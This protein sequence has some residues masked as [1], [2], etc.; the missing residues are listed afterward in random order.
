[1][2]EKTCFFTGNRN[3]SN[4]DYEQIFY[5]N[6]II[7]EILIKEK[8]VTYFKV[9]IDRE[10]DIIAILSIIKIKKAYPNIRLILVMPYKTPL[11][12]WNKK[13]YNIAI[14]N[15]DEIIYIPEYY[16]KDYIFK[17][18]NK[19]IE[20]SD[21]CIAYLR[22]NTKRCGIFYTMLKA[23]NKNIKIYNLNNYLDWFLSKNIGADILGLLQ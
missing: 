16:T 5:L 6:T 13:I 15:A 8:E 21:Y 20:N 22:R 18:N 7:S 10:F 11:I 9:G 23:K 19:L 14:Q 4:K 2:K 3:I 12:N 1:M 17:R